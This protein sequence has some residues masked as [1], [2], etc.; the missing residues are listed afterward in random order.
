M[1]PVGAG[2]RRGE[3]QRDIRHFLC[4]HRERR[5]AK[6]NDYLH[7]IDKLYLVMV[8]GTG[9]RYEAMGYD[10]P[11]MTILF[12]EGHSP[13]HRSDEVPGI[14]YMYDT[15]HYNTA[16]SILQVVQQ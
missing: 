6:N 2:T 7:T 14:I 1:V 9:H 8:P 12:M 16:V 3:G 15:M 5:A 11:K 4:T 10:P 13:Y